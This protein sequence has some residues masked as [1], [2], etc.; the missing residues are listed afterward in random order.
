MS[1]IKLGSIK[2]RRE[3]KLSTV[4]IVHYGNVFVLLRETTRSLR[5]GAKKQGL[6]P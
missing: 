6:C 4:D 1:K 2:D 3:R 5:V